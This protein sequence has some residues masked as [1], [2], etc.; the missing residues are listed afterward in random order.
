M[1]PKPFDIPWTTLWRAFFIVVLAATLF[2]VRDILLI[3]FLAIVISSAL[4][5]PVSFL[6]QYKIPRILGTLVLFLVLLGVISL[7]LYTLIPTIIIEFKGVVGSLANLE[8]PILGPIDLS[9]LLLEF[10]QKLSEYTHIIFSSGASF[11]GIFSTIFGNAVLVLATFVLSFYLT[12]NQSGVEKLLRTLLP[13]THE[14]YVIGIYRRARMRLGQ[15][16]RGQVVLMIIIGAIT[17]AGL[18]MLD[19]KS[20]LVLGVLAGIFELV[21]VAGPIFAGILAFLVA[22]AGS[23]KVGLY[24]IIFFVIIQFL[25]NHV[26]VP[27]VMRKTVGISP[28]MVVVVVSTSSNAASSSTPHTA[29]VFSSTLA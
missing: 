28:V 19:V 16:L 8:L 25:E 20:S 6:Q 22:V 24:V 12:I 1:D 11:L 14:D 18:W 13:V 15:W 17:F 21:P 27:L 2:L 9:Q 10:E 29:E 23:W 7:L 3:L 4:D 26:L 5:G